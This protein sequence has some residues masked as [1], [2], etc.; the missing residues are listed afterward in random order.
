MKKQTLLFILVACFIHTYGQ[1]QF[2]PGAIWPDRDGKHI[3]AHGGGILY[4]GDTYYWFGEFKT[5]GKSGNRAWVGISCY[6][7][8]D[9]YNWKNEGIVLPVVDDSASEITKGCVMERPKV[10]YNVKTKK[11]VLWF[12]LELKEQGYNAARTAVA[13]SDHPTGPYTYIRSYRPDSK[14]WPM[15][16]DKAW[17]TKTVH[18][19]E[20]KAHTDPWRKEVA[21]G[22]FIRRDFEKGQMS[23]DMTLFV[24]DD[25]KAYHIHAAEE[26]LT[27]HVSQL[28]D[29]YLSFT[30]KWA[31]IAPAG[32]NEAPALIKR[33]GKYILVTSGCT[34]WEPNAARSF[35]SASIWG[36]WKS[37]GNPAQ[38]KNA[39]R[40]FESQSTYILPVEGR[41]DQ[42]IF[43]ADRWVPD[44]AMDGR[45]IW[46]P[47]TFVGDKP[48]IKWF[49]KWSLEQLANP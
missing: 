39:E 33:N 28:T 31:T 1:Q 4:H 44:N 6:S 24:D 14:T 2:Q 20:L 35:V 32:H 3:N 30:G 12:H 45:Y 25:G 40:T 41:K 22:L 19:S 49:D 46:L 34:G 37:L 5:E 16:F 48:V 27:L 23:R 43:M 18:E 10:I 7:S 38:G 9:L 11:F 17:Q 36:P 29:D 15:N 21:E 13:V 42:Y 26:N 8:K 47:L